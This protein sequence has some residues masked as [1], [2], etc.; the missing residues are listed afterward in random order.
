MLAALA[1]ICPGLGP[2]PNLGGNIFGAALGPFSMPISKCVTH[3]S[4]RTA[5]LVEQH[6]VIMILR[7]WAIQ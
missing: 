4:I 7:G 5:M 2:T 1:L 6:Q 3:W